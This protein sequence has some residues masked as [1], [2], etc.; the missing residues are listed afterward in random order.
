MPPPTLPGTPP[1]I[2]YARARA[3]LA[4]VAEAVAFL[5]ARGVIHRDIKPDNIM[6]DRDTG[7]AMVTDFGIARDL[8]SAEARKYIEQD[9]AQVRAFLAELGLAK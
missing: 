2:D 1:V 3:V 8:R 7:R 5:H 9:N 4:Q 6:I